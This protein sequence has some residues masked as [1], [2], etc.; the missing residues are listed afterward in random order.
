MRFERRILP[1]TNGEEEDEEKK[2]A[3]REE[4]RVGGL[5]ARTTL[6]SR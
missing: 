2:R 5:N 1:S 4:R 6:S 3:R